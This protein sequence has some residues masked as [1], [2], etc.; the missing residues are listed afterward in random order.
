MNT[1]F[2]NLQMTSN[3][4]KEKEIESKAIVIKNKTIIAKQSYWLAEFNPLSKV[5]SF[6]K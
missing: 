3:K 2:I 6:G 5:Y 4:S 1:L